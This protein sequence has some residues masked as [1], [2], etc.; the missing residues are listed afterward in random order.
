[1]AQATEPGLPNS[2]DTRHLDPGSKACPEQ[3]GPEHPRLSTHGLQRQP[4]GVPGPG[5]HFPGT[6]QRAGNW[7]VE[8]SWLFPLFPLEQEKMGL[9]GLI[10]GRS[11]M[12]A[13]TGLCTHS[14]TQEA[15]LD[16]AVLQ[17]SES[18][19]GAAF[20]LVLGDRPAA[21]TTHGA[22]AAWGIQGLWEH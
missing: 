14:T 22:N 8:E 16:P 4:L 18:H 6:N 15:W 19:P 13:D 21:P 7:G 1:M 12:R 3:L 5:I 2:G 17:R 11:Q 9:V 20:P 10:P